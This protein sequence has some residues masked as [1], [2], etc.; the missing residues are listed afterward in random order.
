MKK[1]MIIFIS[2]LLLVLVI[3]YLSQGSID[4][5]RRILKLAHGLNT[6]HPVHKAMEFMAGRASELSGGELEVQIFSK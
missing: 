6:R 4:R 5:N 3:G 2:L 1:G